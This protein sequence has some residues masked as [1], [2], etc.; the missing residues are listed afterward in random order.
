MNEL[1]ASTDRQRISAAELRKLPP[2]ERAVILQAQARLAEEIYRRDRELTDFEAFG[3]GDL[4]G[5]GT[6]P[7]E[8]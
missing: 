4:H 2:G 5:D 3:E 7:E 6:R 1:Q 8:G